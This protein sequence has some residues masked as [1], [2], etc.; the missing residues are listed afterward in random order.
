MISNVAVVLKYLLIFFAITQIQSGHLVEG[1]KAENQ[2]GVS[3]SASGL[4]YNGKVVK[5]NQW[6]FLVALMM[7]ADGKFFCSGTL[8]SRSHV[9]TAAHCLQEKG[10][11]TPST[12]SEFILHLGK[13]NLSLVYECGSITVFPERIKIHPNWNIHQEKYDSDIALIKIEGTVPIRTNIFPACLWTSKME[14]IGHQ[15][16]TVVGW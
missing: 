10:Q 14:A 5:R 15:T 11:E 6:P 7:V 16:G 8:I 2:C 9:L 1:P 13:Y 4:I 12:P 3:L